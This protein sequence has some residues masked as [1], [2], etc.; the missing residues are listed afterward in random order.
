MAEPRDLRAILQAQCHRQALQTSAWMNQ[1]CRCH[2]GG[3]NRRS[4]GIH[5]M[6]AEEMPQIASGYS[7]K[8]KCW[9]GGVGLVA[10]WIASWF[11]P[12]VAY[13]HQ[14]VAMA[15]HIQSPI[16]PPWPIPYRSHRSHLI[17]DTSGT[18][19]YFSPPM[20]TTQRRS[21]SVQL[22]LRVQLG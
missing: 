19:S 17:L 4:I 7:G 16:I 5:S 1:P 6:M 13:G 10:W 12:F 20:T 11:Y 14:R 15:C 3:V 2:K 21:V 22:D 8:S 9:M 18:S